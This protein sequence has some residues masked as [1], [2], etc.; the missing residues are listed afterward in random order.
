MLKGEG[1]NGRSILAVVAEADRPALEA[2]IRSAADKQGEIAPVD[3]AIAGADERFA[4]CYVTVVEEEGD[5][6]AA[7]VYILETTEQRA[8]QNQVIQQQKIETI[9]K[10]AGNI[11]HDFNNLLGAIM[12]ASDFLVNAHK[13]TDPSFQDIIQIRQN[14]NRAAALVRHLLAFSRKQTMRLEVHDLGEALNDLSTLLQRLIGEKVKLDRNL[15]RDLWP[16]RVD[17]GQFE[18]VII[19]LAVNARDAMPDGGRLTLRTANLR[20]DESGELQYKGMPIGEYVVVEA[21]DTGTGIPPEIKDKIWDPFFTTKEIGKG[22]GLGLSTAY[23]IIKQTGGFIYVETEVGKGTTFRIFL[24]RYIPAADD[25]PCAAT[26]RDDARRRLPAPCRRPRRRAAP[27]PISPATAPSC[28]SRT[29]RD[30][31]RSTRAGWSHGASR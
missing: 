3:A 29:R 7:I 15:G 8:L 21:E 23:G 5:Q 19:N 9:G 28:W 30:C 16:V 2:A 1:T 6:E 11:A 24:P 12:M 4:R 17:L 31:G 10:L 18:Q 13:P 26:A 14:A 27:P 22:T 25:V 20:A